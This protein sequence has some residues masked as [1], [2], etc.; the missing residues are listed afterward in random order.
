[1]AILIKKN[2]TINIEDILSD[3]IIFNL[4]MCID[5]EEMK[6]IIP[7]LS[8]DKNDMLVVDARKIPNKSYLVHG[9][10]L[11]PDMIKTLLN[12]GIKGIIYKESRKQK[13][14]VNVYKV[15]KDQY[16]NLNTS[17]YRKYKLTNGFILFS[18]DVFFK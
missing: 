10:R 13:V 16:E 12:I 3:D 11:S 14:Y 9:I 2:T 7:T 4:F 8:I 15:N 5:D 17:Q 6:E 1:M 18:E